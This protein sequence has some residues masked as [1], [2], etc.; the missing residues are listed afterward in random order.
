MRPSFLRYCSEDAE[1]LASNLPTL[2]ERG[3]ALL[4]IAALREVRDESGLMRLLGTPR[5]R[6]WA[7][8]IRE[9]ALSRWSL[10]QDAAST[11]RS[12]T[13]AEASERAI[14]RLR[15]EQHATFWIGM[16]DEL[17]VRDDASFLQALI[18]GPG[19]H[20]IDDEES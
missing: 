10:I 5:Q 7:R 19:P 16:R 18:I 20:V 8:L 9:Q 17:A 6:Q 1:R 14:K 4:T 15:Q 11:Q 12:A 3:D 13:L 2:E